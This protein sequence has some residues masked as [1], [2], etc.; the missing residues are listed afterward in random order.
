MASKYAKQLKIPNE[1]PQ[2]LKDLTREVLREQTNKVM[3]KEVDILGFA[4]EYFKKLVNDRDALTNTNT[5]QEGKDGKCIGGCPIYTKDEVKH[6]VYEGFQAGSEDEA[7]RMAFGQFNWRFEKLIKEK[8]PGLSVKCR[9]QM[10][11]EVDEDETGQISCKELLPVFVELVQ[12]EQDALVVRGSGLPEVEV[13]E[14][15]VVHGMMNEQLESVVLQC[16]SVEDTEQ[17]GTLSRGLCKRALQSKQLGFTRQEINVMMQHVMCEDEDVV[18][19]ENW[20][21]TICNVAIRMHV[22]K[23]VEVPATQEDVLSLFTEIYASN[24][25]DNS[26]KFSVGQLE[27]LFYMADVGLTILQVRLLLGEAELDDQGMVDYETFITNNT[28]MILQLTSFEMQNYSIQEL[29]EYR[30]SA[31]AHCVLHNL[32]AQ[33][34]EV[35]S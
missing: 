1:F 24:D 28:T 18:Q 20:V 21:S 4:A 5:N 25:Q 2:V 15:A 31:K 6:F 35:R 11:A 34:F 26:G 13:P 22:K 19:Y 33:D 14:I 29:Q 32:N 27:E 7:K 16:F 12:Q 30:N 9:D 17:N 8:F 10:L 23:S 3:H